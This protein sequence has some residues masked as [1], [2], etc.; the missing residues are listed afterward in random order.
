[1]YDILGVKWILQNLVGCKWQGIRF[2]SLLR[3]FFVLNTYNLY[4]V[5]LCEAQENMYAP[6]I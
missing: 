1:M 3:F 6:H 2:T 5:L 4:I